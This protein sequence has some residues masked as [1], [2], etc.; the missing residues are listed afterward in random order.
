LFSGRRERR[1]AQTGRAFD[2]PGFATAVRVE[3]PYWNTRVDGEL[4]NIT[5]AAATFGW[6]AIP[7]GYQEIAVAHDKSADGLVTARLF[8]AAPTIESDHSAACKKSPEGVDCSGKV[9][10]ILRLCKRKRHLES[11]THMHSHLCDQPV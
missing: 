8:F 2:E 7:N 4:D 9:L 6:F 11:V 5:S 1:V 10:L 3:P